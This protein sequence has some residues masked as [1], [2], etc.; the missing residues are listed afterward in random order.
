MPTSFLK[1]LAE[2]RNMSLSKVEGLWNKAKEI[3]SKKYNKSSKSYWPLVTSITEK[4]VNKS[5]KSNYISKLHGLI[6][7]K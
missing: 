7:H 1:N 5:K 3:V 2:K 4:L 6:R